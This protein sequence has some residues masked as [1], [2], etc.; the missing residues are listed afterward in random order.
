MGDMGG[1]DGHGCH[2]DDVHD[3]LSSYPDQIRHY[4]SAGYWI[5]ELS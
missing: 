2:V 4:V 1:V 3:F 5:D